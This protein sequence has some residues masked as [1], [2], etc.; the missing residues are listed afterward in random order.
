MHLQEEANNKHDG[1]A[2][3]GGLHV[4]ATDRST[5][6][7][8]S[9]VYCNISDVQLEVETYIMNSNLHTESETCGKQFVA[10]YQEAGKEERFLGIS[11][12]Y[13]SSIFRS[14]ELEAQWTDATR[15]YLKFPG[16]A[17]SLGLSYTTIYSGSSWLNSLH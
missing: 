7:R 2:A 15:S 16:R 1:H 5:K 8:I 9:N 3:A 6:C 14:A 10:K 11:L 17:Y 12:K 4:P 13:S